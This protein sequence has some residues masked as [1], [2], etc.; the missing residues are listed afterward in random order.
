[1]G[2]FTGTGNVLNGVDWTLRIEIL[3]YA[4]V[5][6]ISLFNAFAITKKLKPYL[7]P[8]TVIACISLP[9]FP[10]TPNTLNS[11]FP[12]FMIGAALY[13]YERGRVGLTFL[14]LLTTLVMSTSGGSANVVGL[15]LFFTAWIARHRLAN[16]H[17]VISLA[18][19][20]YAV[21]LF[22]AWFVFYIAGKLQPVMPSEFARMTIAMAVLF[23]VCYAAHFVIEK[24]FI[25]IG[26]TLSKWP[27]KV[28]S[29]PPKA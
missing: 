9:L 13:F 6:V 4:F 1:M 8:L 22:H 21:Y 15:G 25:A 18:S 17:L 19:V 29:L 12:Y 20:S 28:V 23:A 24:P 14:V 3:F 11:Y 16:S 5:F 10:N 7:L 27:A 2:D 26:K